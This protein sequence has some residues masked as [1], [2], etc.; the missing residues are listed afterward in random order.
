MVEA[1]GEWHTSDNKYG[2]AAWKTK[3][4][5][6][7]PKTLSPRKPSSTTPAKGTTPAASS[8]LSNGDVP[9]KPAAVEITILDDSDD[10]DEGRVKRELSPSFGGSSSARLPSTIPQTQSQDEVID[11]TLDSDDEEPPRPVQDTLKRKASEAALSPT[12][13]IWKKG[14]VDSEPVSSSSTLHLS[15]AAPLA[16]NSSAANSSATP[17]RYPST[18]NNGPQVPSLFS[19]GSG[20]SFG[21]NPSNSGAPQL[22]PLTST[23]SG[24]QST[25]QA[26]GNSNSRWSGYP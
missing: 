20:S 11:L 13:S 5:P 16:A 6:E 9:K 1:D 12:E 24:L 21:R 8:S 7:K 14:R 4:P 17:I 19:G 26:N 22:P 23:F 15:R 18:Y 10:E 3:H 25:S 2:S